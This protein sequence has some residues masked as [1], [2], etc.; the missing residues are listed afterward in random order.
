VTEVAF[1]DAD[2]KPTLHKEGYAK[3]TFAYDQR[4]NQ[5]EGPFSSITCP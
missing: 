3:E 2:G 5:I 4:G 1:F